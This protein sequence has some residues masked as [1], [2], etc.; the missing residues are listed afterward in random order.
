MTPHWR[1]WNPSWSGSLMVSGG[2][3]SEAGS[4][5]LE[6]VRNQSTATRVSDPRRPATAGSALQLH[7]KCEDPK[8]A[9]VCTARGCAEG[10]RP[11]RGAGIMT[12]GRMADARERE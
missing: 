12:I 5:C 10:D 3:C 7:G 8:G 11:G 6:E 2:V 9:T 1:R 4:C